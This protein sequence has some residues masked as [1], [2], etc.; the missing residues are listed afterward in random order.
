MDIYL[1]PSEKASGAAVVVLP[2]GGYVNLSMTNEGSSIAKMLVSHDIAAFVVRYRHGPRYHYPA[3]QIDGQ[4]ALR[5]VRS[6]AA[7]Y[8]IQPDRIG[9]LGFS[10][11]GHLAASLA[12]LDIPAPEHPDEIDKLSA[13]PDFAVLMYPVINLTDD[14]VTH[15]G[16]R[17]ALTQEDPALFAQLSPEQHVSKET[18]PVFIVQG[19]DDRT[20]PVMNSVLFYEACL[21]NKV[22]AEMHLFENGRHGF[23]LGGNDPSLSS[24]PDLMVK[25]MAHNK[26]LAAPAAA[27]NA[28]H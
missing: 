10:A 6:K 24:W 7:E 5:T 26:W 25:W 8:H 12:T 21:K 20:V 2:G 16:S 19:M 17:T 27:G 4:R 28:A 22:P 11:G 15:K 9:V 23:G 18:P 3:P 1:P 13:R 14:A